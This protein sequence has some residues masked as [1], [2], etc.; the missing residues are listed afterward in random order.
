MH[1][2]FI[3]YHEKYTVDPVM[4]IDEFIQEHDQH[5]FVECGD[6]MMGSGAIPLDELRQRA[7]KNGIVE[8]LGRNSEHWADNDGLY[9][10]VVPMTKDNKP[11]VKKIFDVV[12]Y[13]F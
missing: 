4:S 8:Y 12:V 10:Q 13:P 3:R 9:F 1:P 11:K 2:E 7:G 6:F 5:G